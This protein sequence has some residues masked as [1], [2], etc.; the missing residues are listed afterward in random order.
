MRRAVNLVALVLLAALLSSG[1]L[2][3]QLRVPATEHYV[4]LATLCADGADEADAQY[5]DDVC[6]SALQA[7]Y[8]A[9]IVRGEDGDAC[10][11]GRPQ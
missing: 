8:I 5:V 11:G 7:C 3:G 1:C 4:Q 10:E 9:A 6:Q 2:A